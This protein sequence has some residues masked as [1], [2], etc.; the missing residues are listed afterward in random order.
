MKTTKYFMASALT[1]AMGATS[2]Y[3]MADVDVE[4]FVEEASEKN[5][6]EI[7]AG[8]LALEKSQDPAVRAFAQKMINDH[9]A[10]NTELRGIATANK[11]ELEDDATMGAKAKAAILKQRDGE[12]FD[13]AY[14]NNQVTAHRDAIKYY[15]DAA[16]SEN[17]EV[18]TFAVAALPKLQHHLKEAETLAAKLAKHNKNVDVKAEVNDE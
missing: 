9:T 18:R 1:L 7:E 5:I 17:T 14:A 15:E 6:A 16:K 11:V 8:K 4:D 3:A 10:N 12:S 13:V 2:F